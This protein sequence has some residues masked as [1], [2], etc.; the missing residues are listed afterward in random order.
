MLQIE[1]GATITGGISATQ[2]RSEQR[3]AKPD[4]ARTEQKPP[5]RSE[6]T[7]GNGARMPRQPDIAAME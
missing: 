7:I 6:A 1:Q 2:D 5:A 3:L 4:S